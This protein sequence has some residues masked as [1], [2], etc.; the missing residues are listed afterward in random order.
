M[1]EEINQL[2][3]AWGDGDEAA[4]EKLTPRVYDN[5]R[6]RTRRKSRAPT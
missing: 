1:K 3:A 2:L 4:P 5:Q 6:W